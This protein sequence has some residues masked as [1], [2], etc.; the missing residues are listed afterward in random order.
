MGERQLNWGVI[1]ASNIAHSRMIPAINGDLNSRVAA[2]SA[3]TGKAV[4]ISQA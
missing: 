4:A 1:G 3:A 2:E